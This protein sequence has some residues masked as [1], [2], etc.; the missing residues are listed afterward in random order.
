MGAGGNGFAGIN[1]NQNLGD[2]SYAHSALQCLLMHP[3]MKEG[4]LNQNNL[5]GNINRYQLTCEIINIYNSVKGGQT[6]NSSN[7]IQL[8]LNHYNQKISGKITGAGYFQKDPYHFL[9]YLLILLHSELNQSPKTFDINRFQNLTI[10]E[11]QNEQLIKNLYADFF[12]QNYCGSVIFNNFYNCEKSKYICPNCQTFYDCD[13]FCIF[14]MDVQKT[15]EERKKNNPNIQTN[16]TLDDCFYYYCNNNP[17][18]CPFCDINIYRYVKIFNG[19][20]II[21]RFKRN[22]L[23]NKCDIQFPIKFNFNKYSA[24]GNNSN[25]NYI[26]K[27]CI[28]YMPQSYKYFTDINTDLN[29]DYG[30]WTRYMDSQKQI[31]NSFNEVYAFE[32]QILIYE[33]LNLNQG[34]NNIQDFRI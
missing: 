13:L 25:N 16:L 8:F 20:T 24:S 3:I 29:S 14:S 26:L 10:Q 9:K 6:G 32:P 17:M 33:Q 7:F 19:K 30:Q 28:S 4:S 2:C 23:G 5:F 1:T 18:K 34:N 31:L 22:N 27:S 11:R 12:Q 21:I 15:Y